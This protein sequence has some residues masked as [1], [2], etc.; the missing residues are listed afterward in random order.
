M[1]KEVVGSNPV[2]EAG[3]PVVASVLNCGECSNR[4]GPLGAAHGSV[5]R[6]PDPEEK[7]TAPLH[8]VLEASQWGGCVTTGRCP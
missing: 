2:W 7:G 8:W 4:S 6:G 3:R 5:F 1:R